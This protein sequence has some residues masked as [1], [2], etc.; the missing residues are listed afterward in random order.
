MNRSISSPEGIFASFDR[1]TAWLRYFLVSLHD[2]QALE[3]V[4]LSF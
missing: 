3:V 1:L 2:S 4:L